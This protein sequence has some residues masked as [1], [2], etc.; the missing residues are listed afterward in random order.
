MTRLVNADWRRLADYVRN[1]RVAQGFGSQMQLAEAAGVS[2]GSVRSIESG[3]THTR[4][5]V[6]MPKIENALGWAPGTARRL[7]EGEDPFEGSTNP[8]MTQEQKD[9]FRELV[10]R[11]KVMSPAVRE[12]VLAEI[13]A[14]PVVTTT[15]E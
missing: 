15:D 7:L 2:E 9:R 13:D 14:T 4:M 8:P 10:L 3:K 1:A 6:V 12:Q 11:S 5:P